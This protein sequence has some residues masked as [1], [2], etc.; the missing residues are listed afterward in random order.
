MYRHNHRKTALILETL[1]G[2]NLQSAL[3]SGGNQA[4]LPAVQSNPAVISST[5]ID[6]NIVAH[7]YHGVVGFFGQ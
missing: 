5:P 4:L 2:R 3:V 7:G 6:V 1:E